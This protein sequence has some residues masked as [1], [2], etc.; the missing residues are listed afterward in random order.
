MNHPSLEELFYGVVTL[1]E[2]GQVVIPAEARREMGFEP[3]DK[4]LVFAHPFG[5]G[6][7]LTKVD[8]IQETIAKTL[9]SLEWLQQQAQKEQGS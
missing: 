2:R 8:R 7:V 5:H 9:A 4:L 3:G 6:I 1:G